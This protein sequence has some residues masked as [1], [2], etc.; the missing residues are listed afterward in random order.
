MFEIQPKLVTE[1][2]TSDYEETQ[3]SAEEHSRIQTQKF[4]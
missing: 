2:K 3:I 1:A 4:M